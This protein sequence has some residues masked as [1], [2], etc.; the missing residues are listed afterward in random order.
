MRNAKGFVINS[1]ICVTRKRENVIPMKHFERDDEFKI[2]N[3]EE[4]LKRQKPVV[5]VIQRQEALKVAR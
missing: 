4:L 2:A 5:I 3:R 1:G